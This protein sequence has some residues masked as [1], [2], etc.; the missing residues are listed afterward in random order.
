MLFYQIKM[1]VVAIGQLYACDIFEK[2]EPHNL[3]KMT[4]LEISPN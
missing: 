1:K 2:S 4:F 3:K